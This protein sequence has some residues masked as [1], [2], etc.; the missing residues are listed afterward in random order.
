MSGVRF[1]GPGCRVRVVCACGG[2]SPALPPDCPARSV[3][4]SRVRGGPGAGPPG[5]HVLDWVIY[6]HGGRSRSLPSLPHTNIPQRPEHPPLRPRPLPLTGRLTAGGG[7]TG[8]A[9]PHTAR[10]CPQ[11]GVPGRRPRQGAHTSGPGYLPRD[12]WRTSPAGA[13]RALPMSRRRRRPSGGRSRR[14]PMWGRPWHRAFLGDGRRSAADRR[15]QGRRQGQPAGGRPETRFSLGTT[16]NEAAPL[17]EG[18]K[19]AGTRTRQRAA[20]QGAIP[21]GIGPSTP[22]ASDR[23]SRCRSQAPPPWLWAFGKACAATPDCSQPPTGRWSPNRP[24]GRG[25]RGGCSGR[26]GIF[27][28]GRDGKDLDRPPC[29]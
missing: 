3:T 5:L 21:P 28:C 22:F 27:V 18:R 13:R 19:R 25:R 11:Q 29:T 24:R 1:V 20:Q 14:A 16:P 8:G 17:A 10:N 26:C 23:R 9:P 2:L 15:Q 6:V 12:D 4:A 7:V